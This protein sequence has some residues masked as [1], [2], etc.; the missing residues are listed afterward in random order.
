MK[1][2]TGSYEMHA[3]KII[4]LDGTE[5][6]DAKIR[7]VPGLFHRRADSRRREADF[8]PPGQGGADGWRAGAAA[9]SASRQR[10]RLDLARRSN[11]GKEGEGGSP[12]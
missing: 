4:L 7:H 5:I 8:V 2:I 9:T 1:K 12:P 10:R 3:E 11:A 6:D